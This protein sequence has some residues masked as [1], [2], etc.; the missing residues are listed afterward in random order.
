[1][2]PNAINPEMKND[3]L[4]EGYYE[5]IFKDKIILANENHREKS[6]I[7]EY[8]SVML[9]EEKE[10]FKILHLKT[11]RAT[12]QYSLLSS[13]D[14]KKLLEKNHP[15]LKTV[16]KLELFKELENNLTVE[17]KSYKGFKI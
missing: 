11:I 17:N 5:L 6:G 4:K 12:K 15:I 2:M 1:M 9:N 8:F 3:L 16:E 13:E 7:N 14:A 10:D